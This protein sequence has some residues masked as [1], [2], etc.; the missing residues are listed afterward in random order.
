MALANPGPQGDEVFEPAPM[1]ASAAPE[2]RLP[3]GVGLISGGLISFSIGALLQSVWA[4]EPCLDTPDGGFS[5]CGPG[6]P[7]VPLGV[8]GIVLMTAG[9]GMTIP[10]AIITHR[11]RRTSSKRQAR[12]R[13]VL[14]LR[15]AGLA[16]RF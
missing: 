10:G 14:S 4:I 15:F 1:P 5:S 2:D 3:L 13:P 12:L 7:I 11:A 16:G 6:P 8:T 9:A